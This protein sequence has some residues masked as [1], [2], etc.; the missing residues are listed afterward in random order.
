MVAALNARNLDGWLAHLADDAQMLP[1]GAPAVVGKPAIRQLLGGLLALQDFSVAHRGATVTVGIGGD[2]AY[3]QYAY[4]L[5][6]PDTAGG[7]T[8][9]R[10][11]DL[12]VYRKRP[13]GTW[14]LVVDMWSP[15]R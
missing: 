3:V 11:K 15:D 1:P 6:V 8:T 4:E 10:G 2:L 5:T 7:S 13:D 14:A 9:E 12:S